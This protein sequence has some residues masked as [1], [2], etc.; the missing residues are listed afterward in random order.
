[1]A[2]LIFSCLRLLQVYSLLLALSVNVLLLH[3][4]MATS[5]WVARAV[6][7][8]LLRGRFNALV[9][10]CQTGSDLSSVYSQRK[11][12]PEASAA[13]CFIIAGEFI[14]LKA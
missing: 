9:S 3:L 1:M 8:K 6:L 12:L 14:N 4:T 11:H 5:R 10:W 7:K 2:P 13:P